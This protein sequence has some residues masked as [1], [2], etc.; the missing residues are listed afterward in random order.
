MV[1][2][3]SS[4]FLSFHIEITPEVAKM[5]QKR[6]VHPLLSFTHDIS[7]VKSIYINLDIDIKARK[8]GSAH[9]QP[10]THH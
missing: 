7:Y 2:Y 3:F 9:F 10:W 5:V 4:I 1:V 8:L 6:S